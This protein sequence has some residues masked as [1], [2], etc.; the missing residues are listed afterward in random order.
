MCKNRNPEKH[1]NKDIIRTLVTASMTCL[2]LSAQAA[3][4]ADLSKEQILEI[5]LRDVG[6]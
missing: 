1:M 6:T 3:T 5:F 4:V 2:A